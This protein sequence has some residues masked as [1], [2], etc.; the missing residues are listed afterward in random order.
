MLDD[1]TSKVSSLAGFLVVVFFFV[2]QYSRRNSMVRLSLSISC[3]PNLNH[4]IPFQLDAIPTV[5]FSDPILSH[6]SAL[7][8]YFSSTLMLKEGCEKVICRTLYAF[9]LASN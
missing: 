4:V 6:L 3:M 5:G 9:F 2:N 8:F 1:Y 7:R